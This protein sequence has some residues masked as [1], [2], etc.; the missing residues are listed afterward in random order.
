MSNSELDSIN[1]CEKLFDLDLTMICISEV[2]TAKFA[3]VNNAFIEKFGYTEDDLLKSTFIDFL[4][5][6]DIQKTKDVIFT[7]LMEGKKVNNFINRYKTVDGDYLTIEW[8]SVP[9]ENNKYAISIAKDIT[10]ELEEKKLLEISNIFFQNIQKSVPGAFFEFVLTSDGKFQLPYV[11]ENSGKIIENDE[12]AKLTE[13]IFFSYFHKDDIDLFKKKVYESAENMTDFEHEYRLVVNDKI[14]WLRAN[15]KPHKND[16]GSTIWYGYAMDITE[17][18][19]M[20]FQLENLN[21]SKDKFFSIISHDL[22]SPFSGFLGL[23]ELLKNEYET[24]T[25]AD[26]KQITNSIYNSSKRIYKLLDD[27]LLWSNTQLGRIPFNS[28]TFNAY[29]IIYNLVFLYQIKAN[30]KAVDIT[31]DSQRD[32]MIRADKN[33][34]TTIIR[35]LLD[36]AI[37]FT[38]SGDFIIIRAKKDENQIYIEVEDTGVGMK[39]E[40]SSNLFKIDKKIGNIGTKGE[41]GSGLGLILCREF[42]ERHN[43]EIWVESELDKGSKFSFSI[44]N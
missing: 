4:H 20:R 5:T 44:P 17:T 12:I 31:I 14:K 25:I 11:G 24:L 28:E 26:I 41:N 27:L 33:M 15:S 42:V 32:L 16:E 36:N 35:N 10:E 3:K 6:D 39:N 22:R 7:N 19:E 34:F 43:G 37:K 40:Y 21:K 13:E 29:E 1:I 2:E 30:E 9:L 8:N 23:S 38:N 18:K